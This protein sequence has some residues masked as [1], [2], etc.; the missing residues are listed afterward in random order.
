MARPRPVPFDLPAVAV[1]WKSAA[2]TSRGTDAGSL[3]TSTVIASRAP[4][5]NVTETRP[6]G[7]VRSVRA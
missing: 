7:V 2:R 4:P 1:R 5:S 6:P 3:T